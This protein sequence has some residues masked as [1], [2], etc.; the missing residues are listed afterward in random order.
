MNWRGIP[1]NKKLFVI[2]ILFVNGATWGKLVYGYI[3]H[4]MLYYIYQKCVIYM[5]GV[6]E[7][8]VILILNF[9]NKKILKY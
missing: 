6:S 2:N 8:V 5:Q 3:H 1:D 7:T 9:G 4:D